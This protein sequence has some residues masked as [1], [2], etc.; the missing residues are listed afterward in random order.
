[1]K[2]KLIGLAGR[3]G[4]GKSTVA[5]MIAPSK[6]VELMLYN[7]P[8]AYI[9]SILF[10]WK[11]EDLSFIEASYDRDTIRKSCLLD[12]LSKD[13]IWHFSVLAAFDWTY[14]VLIKFDKDI[15]LHMN[16]EF[17]APYVYQNQDPWIQL[18]FADPLKCICVPISGLPYPVLLGIDAA[19]R[20]SR[21][22]PIPNFWHPTMTGRQLLEQIGTDVFRSVD[23]DIWIK[24]AMR[25]IQAYNADGIGVIISDVRFKN[26]AEMIR[27]LGGELWIIARNPKDLILSDQDCETHVS[28]W[29]FLTFI[30][31]DDLIL[32]NSGSLDELHSSII[33]RLE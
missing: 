19:A 30:T 5:E 12:T 33:N 32:M 23:S 14:D 6:A 7:N 1:M 10:G 18:S 2:S 20:V 25:S 11:Y 13:P 4:A 3:A 31:K 29:E 27:S 15:L 26:E 16:Y 28:K 8:W 21:E 17:K 22:K 9:L 24:L